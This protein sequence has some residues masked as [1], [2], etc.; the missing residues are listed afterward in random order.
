MVKDV[1]SYS[2]L[3]GM[4]FLSVSLGRSALSFNF[5]NEDG[6]GLKNIELG[7]SADICFSE[8]ELFKPFSDYDVLDP[9]Y[10]KNLYSALGSKVLD[11]RPLGKNRACRMD[12]EKLSIFTW[13]GGKE[14]PDCL[15][16]AKENSRTNKYKWWLIDDL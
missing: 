12:F 16:L 15:Y 5:E 9:A 13:A 10:L 6:Q 11:F 4:T 1:S 3:I 7:T 14:W 8:K 2:P